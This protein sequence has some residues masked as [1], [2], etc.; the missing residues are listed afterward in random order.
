MRSRLAVVAC[1]L[2]LWGALA[3]SDDAPAPAD[4]P[5]TGASEVAEV[6]V[7]PGDELLAQAQGELVGGRLPDGVKAQ[8][9]ASPDPAH[10][11]AKRILAVMDRQAR[12]ER[13][14]ESA[15]DEQTQKPPPKLQPPS[16]G[17]GEGEGEG[18]GA[19]EGGAPVTETATGATGGADDAA[20]EPA[21]AKAR[22]AVLT[23]LSLKQKGKRATLTVHAASSVRVG[24][25]TQASG[26]VRLVVESAGALPA[27]LQARPSIDGVTVSDVRRGPDTVQI[28]VDVG[29][30][31]TVGRPTSFSGGARLA[32]TRS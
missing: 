8:I 2:P 1:T 27:V 19:G 15:D 4:A 29:E 24:V 16:E 7:G 11:R 21:P 30:G 26:K 9:M 5:E 22:L 10:A 13:E 25:A 32:F 3:C 18:A 17:E 12:G 14:P 6:E 20:E 23:R 28:A 31:W